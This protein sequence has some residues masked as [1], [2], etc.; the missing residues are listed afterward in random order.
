MRIEPERVAQYKELYK[1]EY[2]KDIS[3]AEAYDGLYALLTLVKI[4]HEPD[5]PTKKARTS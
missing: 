4:M 1:K 3:D 2:G 5:R